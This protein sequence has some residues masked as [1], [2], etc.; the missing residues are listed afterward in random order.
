[1]SM[2]TFLVAGGIVTFLLLAGLALIGFA[3][4]SRERAQPGGNDPALPPSS[5]DNPT[6]P[7]WDQ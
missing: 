2:A 4:R 1:M 6:L 3:N 7:G 5:P